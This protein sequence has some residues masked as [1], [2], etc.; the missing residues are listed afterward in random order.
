MDVYFTKPQARFI[1]S[2]SKYPAFVGG[3]GSGKTHGGIWRALRMKKENPTINTAYY[4]PTYSLIS[5]IAYPRFIELF[6]SLNIPYRQNKKDNFFEIENFGKIIMRSMDKPEKIIGFETGDCVIDELDTLSHDKAKDV[7]GKIVA[8]TRKKKPNGLPNTR[9]VVTTPEG[10]RF[11]YEKWKKDPMK[12][13]E[14]IKAPTSSNPFL[15]DDYIDSLRE[16]HTEALL[17][18]YLMGEFVNMTAASVYSEFK[19][20]LHHTSDTIQSGDVLHIGMDFNVGEMAAVIH[21]LRDN[22]PRAV[23]ELGKI[24][25]TPAM[26]AQIKK[27][28]PEHSIIVYPDASGNN[29]KSQDA[30]Q[31]DIKLLRDAGFSVFVNNKNPR[32]RDRIL[33]MNAMF[34]SGSYLVNVDKCPMYVETLEKQAYDKHG[35]PDKTSGL[36]HHGDAGGYF[37]VYR[38]PVV[39]GETFKF[40]LKGL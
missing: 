8:R 22:Q 35:E 4:L 10:F 37:I 2:N 7:F 24:L 31:S 26:I 13:S 1:S 34:K 39:K 38:Y 32:V 23:D 3:L 5:D 15:P 27:L 33:S 12:G 20:E 30:S 19:R 28:W 25:D 14:L 17:E 21:V 18:A 6:E 16:T 36:D 9:A 29:R 40:K 11:V